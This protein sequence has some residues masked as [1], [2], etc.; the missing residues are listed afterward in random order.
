[1]T[2]LQ[3]LIFWREIWI[4]IESTF[5]RHKI[6]KSQGSLKQKIAGNHGKWI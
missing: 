1:M 2:R 5:S 4:T 6:S 3:F